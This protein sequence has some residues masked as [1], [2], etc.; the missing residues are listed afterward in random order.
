MPNRRWIAG[1]LL[2]L[3]G[4][5]YM[6]VGRGQ[7]NAPAIVEG[8]LLPTEYDVWS[9]DWSPD[10]KTVVFSGKMKGEDSDRM[11]VWLWSPPEGAPTVWTNTANMMDASPRWTPQGDGVVMVRRNLDGVDTG[12]CL[13]SSLWFKAYPSG[14]GVQLTSGPEDRDPAWSPD[15][16]RLVFVRSHGP[17][18]SDLVLIDRSGQN[19]LVLVQG[20][21]NVLATP[22]WAADGWIYYTRYMFHS[23]D[24]KVGAS[25]FSGKEIERGIIERI[26][27]VDGKIEVVVKDEF[28][29]RSPV[30]S[31]DGSRLAF[32]SSRGALSDTMHMYDRGV[33]WVM[34]LKLRTMKALSD[35]AGL[36]GNPP[37]WSPGN[38][39]LY[40]FS[41]RTVRPSIW[42][43]SLNPAP[44]PP[45]PAATT[46]GTG[47]N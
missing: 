36:N 46:T 42:S 8:R 25:S 18:S 11:R 39:T 21:S 41:F 6:P 15:G 5:V 24:I 29:N 33:L 2:I 16:K 31:R 17:Y 4:M 32:I 23:K 45:P 47:T 19:P 13:S 38:D 9:C 3:A 44:P 10:G 22:C 14:D 40:F 34:D 27:P 28:D 7:D 37:T 12:N 1:L 26:S 20:G 43:V 35:R 30:T